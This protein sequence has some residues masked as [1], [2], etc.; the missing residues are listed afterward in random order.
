[1]SLY[2]KQDHSRFRDI[3]KGRIKQNFKKFI[4]QGEMIGKKDKEYISIPVPQIDIPHFQYGPKNQGGVGQG[5]GEQGS[6]VNGDPQDG[7]GKAGNSEGQHIL[8]VDVTF[9]ELAELL[10]SELELPKIEPKGNKQIK[11]LKT[12][13][14]GI[15]TVGSDSLRHFKTTFKQALKRQIITGTYNPH[16]PIIVPNRKDFRFRS[17]KYSEQPQ[18]NAVIIYIMDVSGSMGDEQKEIVRLESF[19]INTW[20]KSQYKEIETRFVIHDAA[21]REVDEDTFFKTRESGGTLI[22][23]AYL[24][25]Y[26]LIEEN[27]PSQDWNIYIFHFSDGDN[28]SGE[29]TRVCVDLLKSKNLIQNDMYFK[30]YLKLKK[31]DKIDAANYLVPTQ[32]TGKA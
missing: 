18:S 2:I 15:H 30:F 17:Y 9:D 26:K 24:L 8:E 1:M 25:T 22:S 3:V 20:L 7:A 11:A 16:D 23:S 21:A 27:Y 32:G 28:W 12:K 31:I 29:D 14:L 13:F 5:E 10:G 6:P 19:W 4:S